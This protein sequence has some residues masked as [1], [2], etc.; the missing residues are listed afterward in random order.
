M[1][2]QEESNLIQYIRDYSEDYLVDDYEI[3]KNS[4]QD[5]K[6]LCQ[7]IYDIFCKEY[8][9]EIARKPEYKAFISWAQGLAMG[10]LFCFWYNREALADIEKLAGKKAPKHFTEEDAEIALT[11]YIYTVIKRNVA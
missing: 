7:A 3:D 1:T 4:I 6:G 2:K 5:A 11:N 10:G 8:G 9:H